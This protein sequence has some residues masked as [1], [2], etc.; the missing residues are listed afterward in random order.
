V[1]ARALA[2]GI[3]DS[4][5][6][7]SITPFY[8]HRRELAVELLES[9]L[10]ADMDWRLHSD[11]NGMFSWLWIRDDWFDDAAFYE[12]LKRARVFVT[13]GRYFFVGPEGGAALGR[14]STQCVRVSLSCELPVLVEGIERLAAGLRAMRRERAPR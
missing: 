4:L 7:Q 5:V 2:S 9:A 3:L 12:R 11:N 14:H 8:R 6:S 10:P 13:P 1:V